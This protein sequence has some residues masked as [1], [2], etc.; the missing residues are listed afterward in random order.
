MGNPVK[1]QSTVDSLPNSPSLDQ[2]RKRKLLKNIRKGE[3]QVAS[4]FVISHSAFYLY[5]NN[6]YHPS[7]NFS[8]DRS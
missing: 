3:T 8:N 1:F 6:L 7:K 5:K 2:T 4:I